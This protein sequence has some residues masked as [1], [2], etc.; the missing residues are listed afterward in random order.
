MCVWNGFDLFTCIV[1]FLISHNN[2]THFLFLLNYLL[3]FVASIGLLRERNQLFFACVPVI[4]YASRFFYVIRCVDFY[5]Y[6]FTL[7]H[8]YS[9]RMTSDFTWPSSN[10]WMRSKKQISCWPCF[11][12]FITFCTIICEMPTRR[13]WP[14]QTLLLNKYQCFCISYAFINRT[15]YCFVEGKTPQ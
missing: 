6:S 3:R 12:Q 1:V 5:I 8:L 9:L 2:L 7:T 13:L 4:Q 14:S 11:P 15:L 10:I